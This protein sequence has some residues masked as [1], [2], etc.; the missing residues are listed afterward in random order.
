MGF[1]KDGKGI[2]IHQRAVITHGTP[3]NGTFVKGSAL[4]IEED[5]RIIK[6]E[7]SFFTTGVTA[8]EGPL[9]IALA[10]DN[11]SIAQIAENL[12]SGPNNRNDYEA[13]EEVSRPVWVFGTVLPQTASLI[14]DSGL[15]GEKTIRWT[16]SNPE[17]WVWGLFN[18]SGAALTTGGLTIVRSKIFGVW[19]S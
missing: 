17:G 5:F 6:V 11:L 3:G 1:G 9:L 15:W 10:A 19:V 16:F 8:G 18:D 4:P 14:P 12:L 2:I 13:L 7:F